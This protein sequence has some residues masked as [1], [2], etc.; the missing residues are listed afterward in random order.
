M[1]II[2]KKINKYI[3]LKYEDVFII[4]LQSIQF[5]KI[6]QF[7]NH[8]FEHVHHVFIIDQLFQSFFQ[9]FN[10]IKNSV[11]DHDTYFLIKK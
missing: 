11:F 5:F 6:V 9:S 10:N 4:L 8:E 1:L 2:C 3:T 7:F